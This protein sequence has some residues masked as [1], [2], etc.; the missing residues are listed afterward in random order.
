MRATMTHKPETIDRMADALAY[1]REF[2][3][4]STNEYV[5]SGIVKDDLFR[6]KSKRLL[7][8]CRNTELSGLDGV[9]HNTKYWH[10]LPLGGPY[11]D[12]P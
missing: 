9:H 2:E 7:R 10:A 12:Y 11:E 6:L 4:L 3:C 5:E 1:V 8:Q